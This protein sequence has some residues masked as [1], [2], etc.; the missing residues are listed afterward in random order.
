METSM[1]IDPDD[2]RLPNELLDLVV[3]FVP[4]P[5]L[6]RIQ[7]VSKTFRHIALVRISLRILQC[8][9]TKEVTATLNTL[10]PVPPRFVGQMMTLAAF[11]PPD[12]GKVV[13]ELVFRQPTTPRVVCVLHQIRYPI[14][15]L[16]GFLSG[17]RVEPVLMPAFIQELRLDFADLF[18]LLG[19]W[20][21]QRTMS[22]PQVVAVIG[23]LSLSSPQLAQIFEYIR[24]PLKDKVELLRR[25][26][27]D[28]VALILKTCTLTATDLI[29]ILRALRASWAD[30]GWILSRLQLGWAAIVEIL[31]RFKLRYSIDSLAI[32]MVELRHHPELIHIL[33][34]LELR[35]LRE[36]AVLV[37]V[38]DVPIHAVARLINELDIPGPFALGHFL[39]ELSLSYAETVELL[40]EIQLG[41]RF[42]QLYGGGHPALGRI[43]FTAEM[44][45]S[46]LSLLL[47]ELRVKNLMDHDRLLR[48]IIGVWH[49]TQILVPGLVQLVADL[50]KHQILERSQA[51]GLV[52]TLVPLYIHGDV[53]R[54]F[55]EQ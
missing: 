47:A 46:Q 16:I 10:E 41:N 54:T 50:H 55:A 51:L 8:Q 44:E 26:S 37:K 45:L 6:W 5:E 2:R 24:I 29:V 30:V 18:P 49:Q 35:Y 4:T 14:H 7:T 17:F 52:K 33:L 31:D 42:D 9:N 3:S 15:H 36:Y 25:E 22:P 1:A 23:S 21:A 53:E 19:H 39:K 13:S 11:P 27:R 20:I 43:L 34:N 28:S 40:A 38:L 32:V 12:V 48:V